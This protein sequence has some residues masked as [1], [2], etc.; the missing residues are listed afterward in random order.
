MTAD[1]ATSSS[2]AASSSGSETSSVTSTTDAVDT[3]IAKPPPKPTPKPNNA[4]SHKSS[5][6]KK[7]IRKGSNSN[8]PLYT[9]SDQFP[10]LD[11]SQ[12]IT[13]VTNQNN[14]INSRLKEIRQLIETHLGVR[15]RGNVRTCCYCYFVD[16]SS[17]KCAHVCFG[18]RTWAWASCKYVAISANTCVCARMSHLDQLKWILNWMPPFLELQTGSV[19]ANSTSKKK[20]PKTHSEESV[21]DFRD[22]FRVINVSDVLR[23]HTGSFGLLGVCV[24]DW[25]SVRWVRQWPSESTQVVEANSY[26]HVCE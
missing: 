11:T 21:A 18:T 7:I 13:L 16:F 3:S 1:L 12:K 17:N 14:L 26:M 8:K 2:S 15:A 4:E 19:S 9:P 22:R 24:S 20:A 23:C 6:T 25:F 5:Q 10:H